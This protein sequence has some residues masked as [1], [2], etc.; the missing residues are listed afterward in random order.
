MNYMILSVDTGI[1]DALAIAYALGQKTYRLL[2]ITVSY[3]MAPLEKT[4]RNTRHLL[5][6]MGHPKVPVY[7]GSS[8]PLQGIRTYNGDF[9]GLD[10]AA[11]LLGEPAWE[12]RP[13]EHMKSSVAFIHESIER[14]GRD[15][16]LVTTGPLTDLARLLNLYPSQCRALGQV[17]SMGGALTC[18]GN[19][20][21]VAEANIKADV[22]A[23]KA[24]LEAGLPLTLIGLDVTRKTLLTWEEIQTWKN[25]G[26]AAG[27]FYCDLLTFY[28]N[29]YRRFYP[30]LQGCALHDP[31]AVAAACC[32]QI[33]TMLPFHLTVC[34]DGPV[35]GRIT[36]NL[37][38]DHGG[39]EET[40]VALKVDS[41]AFKSMFTEM[42][43][44]V[45]GGFA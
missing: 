1:D 6:L 41:H 22:A 29:E 44:Y 2:G 31:L 42:M 25:M 12:E 4:Y 7:P 19:S 43:S 33:F 20:S 27:S 34:T 38:A 30:Y 14:Y 11:N 28:L 37:M 15:L 10:G 24:V 26:T 45:L 5:N 9:H 35:I 39:T 32:P 17:I 8:A 23:S 21:P 13:P 18:P 40:M 36:E 16:T 3:G